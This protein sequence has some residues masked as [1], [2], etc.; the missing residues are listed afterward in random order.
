MNNKELRN[1]IDKIDIILE[2]KA[3]AED[4]HSDAIDKMQ[5]KIQNQGH[6]VVGVKHNDSTDETEIIFEPKDKKGTRKTIAVK[7]VK[8]DAN[9]SD[10]TDKMTEKLKKQGHKV[11][12]IKHNDKTGKTE[13]VYEP[14][15]KKGTRKTT[16]V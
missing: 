10:A 7:S 5:K 2:G 8:E 11:V 14:K 13:I 1:L 4:A 12:G 6:K 16:T 3:V 9:P 15:D